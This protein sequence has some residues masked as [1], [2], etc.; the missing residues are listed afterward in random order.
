MNSPGI[1]STHTRPIGADVGAPV[2][3]ALSSS[4]PADLNTDL[5]TDLDAAVKA[6]GKG[7][8]PPPPRMM[9]VDELAAILG[10]PRASLTLSDVKQRLGGPMSLMQARI[11]AVAPSPAIAPAPLRERVRDA[12]LSAFSLDGLRDLARTTLPSSATDPIVWKRAAVAVVDDLLDVLAQSPALIGPF[13]DAVSAARPGRADVRAVARELRDTGAL[14]LAIPSAPRPP[15]ADAAFTAQV[16]AA[17]VSAFDDSGLRDLLSVCTPPGLVHHVNWAQP[18]NAVVNDV[19]HAL[20]T[21]PEAIATFAHA[22]FAARP[23]RPDVRATA[24]EL[25]ARNAL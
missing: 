14:P 13:A 4:V 18:K 25:R 16:K 2:M 7:D 8:A 23:G 6:N 19:L 21:H 22:M 1:G 15:P 17:L 12:L 3:V 20:R 5:P 11:E 24:T 9:T 10:G